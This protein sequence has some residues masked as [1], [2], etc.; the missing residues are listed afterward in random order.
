MSFLSSPSRTR[1]HP[2]QPL[3]RE[4]FSATPAGVQAALQA[5]ESAGSPDVS[6]GRQTSGGGG[7]WP[8]AEA[9]GRIWGGET[10]PLFAT[11]YWP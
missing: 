5:G 7:N 11:S 4:V 1:G 9:R 6:H 3:H 10:R 2:L 8:G